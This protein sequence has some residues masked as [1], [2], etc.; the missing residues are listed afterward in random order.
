V[1]RT[2]DQY[3]QELQV[4]ADSLPY[5]DIE[6]PEF[7]QADFDPVRIRQERKFVQMDS[8]MPPIS[9]FLVGRGVV[10]LLPSQHVTALFTEL[11]WCAWTIRALA[12][13]PGQGARVRK[14]LVEARKRISRIEAVEEELFIANR[15]LVVSC[16]KPFFWIGQV[17]IGDFLQ[18]GAKA[19][20]NAVRKFDFTRG[21]PFYAYAQKAI[22]N[23]LRNYFRDHV[24]SGS[25]GI[26]PSREMTQIRRILDDWKLEHPGADPPDAAALAKLTELPEALVKKT[27]PFV[28]Q[29]ANTPAPPVSLDA[30]IG[31]SDATLYEVVED[32]E[33]EQATA[34]AE[35]SE[36]WSAVE[37][38]PPRA[39]YI[40][41]LRFIEGL[42]LEETGQRLNLTRA[43]IKQIQDESIRK[44]RYM[45]RRGISDI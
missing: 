26:R 17:W 8:A 34:V 6:L 36:V 1:G 25:I 2:V 22:Q 9:R 39:G 42:T 7:H 4:L 16:V 29:W 23:R 41:R 38:L 32:T 12:A 28:K 44:L 24:R 15:R 43:R 11:H 35:K 14:T 20:T 27:L 5:P 40:M 30:I 33:A 13:N 18:E 19:L 10:E 3:R 45:L 37:R 31:D 21:T